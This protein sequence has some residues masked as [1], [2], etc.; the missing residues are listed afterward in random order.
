MSQTNENVDL[1]VDEAENSSAS[2]AIMIQDDNIPPVVG[3]VS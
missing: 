1:S 3:A 2:V